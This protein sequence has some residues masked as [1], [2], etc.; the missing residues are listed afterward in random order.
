MCGENPHRSIS[1]P[2]F[3][4]S[5]R[6]TGSAEPLGYMEAPYSES[7]SSTRWSVM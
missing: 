1:N 3:A 5:H 6:Q 7:Q 4:V 2:P